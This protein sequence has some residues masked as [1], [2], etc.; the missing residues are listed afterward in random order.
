MEMRQLKYFVEISQRGSF[1]RAAK[2]LAIAQPALSRQIRL[3]EESLGA[4]LLYR[5]GRGVMMT[6]AGE[7]F[8]AY[9]RDVLEKVERAERD[10][11][12]LRGTPRGEVILG[13]P[14]SVSAVLLRR[15][16]VALSERFPLI[17]LRVQEGFSGNVA[18]W[19]LAGKVDLA[20]IYEHHRPQ[21]A[22]A[23]RLLVEELPLV[24]S[25]SLVLPPVLTSV[26]LGAIPLVLPARPHGLRMVVEKRVAEHGGSLDV[27]FEMDS[28]LIMKELA[29][30]GV[31]ATILPVGAVTR[32]V[33]EGRLA[34]TPIV[35]PKI[36][37]VMALATASSRPLE[38]THRA[39]IRVIR[40]VAGSPQGEAPAA[41]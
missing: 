27:R 31:A 25:P 21:S 11:A 37:R 7:I 6:A 10:I 1:S 35:S 12:A 40:E 33:Q 30:E 38:N 29:I 16:I 14:P 41:T 32:E 24:H 36:T 28:L 22:Q 17:R 4:P 5:N 8:L 15:I 34:I 26:D 20:I 2:S 9:A 3:L 18:E 39:V 23:E 19:L 13:L